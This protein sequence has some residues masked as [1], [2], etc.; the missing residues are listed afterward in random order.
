MKNWLFQDNLTFLC[1][2]LD[3]F[4]GDLNEVNLTGLCIR[5]VISKTSHRGYQLFWS[6][7]NKFSCTYVEM[8]LEGL[9]L[10]WML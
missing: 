4:L 8:E 1:N 5:N 9:V 2:K 3:N 6:S 10:F 7:D